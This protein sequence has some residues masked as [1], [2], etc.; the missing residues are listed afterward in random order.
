ML[1]FVQSCLE[2]FWHGYVTGACGVVPVNS[3][4][5]EQGTGPVDGDGVEFLEVL[6]EVVG[7]LFSNVFDSKVINDE[8][9]NDGLGGV[10]PD[11]RGSGNRG[12]N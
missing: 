5:A 12:K 10:L 1:E 11:C 3:D 8:G 9:E 2:I 7:I 4:S 6:N